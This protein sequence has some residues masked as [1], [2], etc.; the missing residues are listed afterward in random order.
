[1]KTLLKKSPLFLVFWL[2]LGLLWS[3]LYADVAPLLQTIWGTDDSW[4]NMCPQDN[5][6]SGNNVDAGTIAVSMAMIMKYFN[7]PSIGQ[8]SNSYVQQPYGVISAN[9]GNT[10]YNWAAM[11]NTLILNGTR[12]LIFHSGVAMN[13][14]YGAQASYATIENAYAALLNNFRYDN[15]GTLVQRSNYTQN[16]WENLIKNELNN[17]RPVLYKADTPDG[18]IGFV[19]DGWQNVN[20]F[21][22]NWGKTGDGNGY[23][24]LNNLAYEGVSMTSGNSAVIGIYPTLGPDTIDENFETDFSDW[25]WQFSGNANWNINT[26]EHFYGLQSAKSGQIGHNQTTSMFIQFFV[27]TNDVI[28]FY[29][30]VSCEDSPGPTPTY[31]YLSFWIDDQ[32]MARWHGESFW[33]METFPVSAGLRTFRWTYRKDGATIEGQDC[34]WID[35]IDFPN[36]EIPLGPVQNFAGEII[37]G[38][39]ISLSWSQPLPFQRNL[40]G[41]RIYKNGSELVS[42]LNPSTLNYVDPNLANGAY[43]YYVKA[44]YTTGLSNPSPT[45]NFNVEVPYAPTGLTATIY[46]EDNVALQ[47]NRPP[48]LRNRVLSGYNIYRNNALLANISDPDDTDYQD[49]DLSPAVYN[50]YVTALYTV[51]ESPASNIAVAAVGVPSPPTGL[52][53]T[54]NGGNNVSLV[55]Q[56]PLV[57]RALLGYKVFRN[58]DLVV[59][60]ND[61]ATLTYADL[62]LANGEYSYT[63][64]TVYTAAE[65]QPS[66]PA[67]VVI[68]VLYAPLNLLYAIENQINVRLSWTFPAAP[69]ALTGYN[70]YRN[71]VLVGSVYNPN[72]LFFLDEDLANGSYQ[73]H[74]KAVYT[75][76]TSPSSNTV[77]VNIEVLYPPRNVVA[78]VNQSTVNL[79]WQQP[80]NSGGLRALNGYNIYQ[81]GNQIGYVPVSANRTYSIANLANGSYVFAVSAVYGTGESTLT[82]A[83][84]A[85]VEVLYPPRNLS[86]TQIGLDVNLFWELPQTAPRALL[87]YTVYR[88]NVSHATVDGAASLSFSD[89]NLDTGTYQYKV[90]ARYTNG[91]S[92]FSNTVTINVENPYPPHTLVAN[93]NGSN[94]NLSWQ[95]PNSGRVFMHYNI[96]RG[97]TLLTTTANTSYVDAN[98]PNGGYSYYVSA[99][100]T[101]AESIPTNTVNATVLVLNPVRSF[102]SS[103]FNRNN[104]Q[105]SWLPP[106]PLPHGSTDQLLGYRLF[107]NGIVL[108]EQTETSYTDAALADGSYAY[109]VVAV[110]NSGTSSPSATQT[111]VIEYPFPVQNLNATV[112]SDAITLNWSLSSRAITRFAIYRNGSF[113]ANA[114]GS[115]NSYTDQGLAN[116]SYTY[117]IITHN[118]SESGAS[119]PSESVSATVEVLYPP[120]NLAY[121]QNENLISLTWDA[122]QTSG[123][124]AFLQYEVYR[125][126]VMIATTTQT[127]YSESQSNGSYTYY[128][129]AI[130]DSGTSLPSNSVLVNILIIYGP[131]N[132]SLTQV[133]NDITLNW[134]AAQDTGAGS[135]FIHYQIYRNGSMIG[136]SNNLSYADFDLPNGSYSYYVTAL[137]SIGESQAT[138]TV[139]TIVELIYPPLSLIANVNGNNVSLIWQTDPMRSF[140]GY[141]IYRNGS[142][143]AQTMQA[144]YT[145]T[146]LPNGSYQYSITA[147]YD[148][149]ESTHSNT[150]NVVIEILYA[151]A[152]LSYLVDG[153]S[154]TLTWQAEPNRSFQTYLVYRNGMP[155]STTTNT[156]YTDDSLAN[157]EY[158]YYVTAIYDTGE[159]LPS[160]SVTAIV[161]VLYAPANLSILVTAD[162]ADLAWQAAPTSSMGRSFLGYN[163]YRNGML[164]DSTMNLVYSDLG[165]ANGSYSYY[166]TAIYSSGESLPT[167]TVIATIEVLYPP[168][169][170]SASVN[171]NTVS[172]VWDLPL[173]IGGLRDLL[174]Y[175]IYRNNLLIDQSS[176]N[177]YTDS[178]LRNGAYSYQV[179]AVY[180]SG[181]STPSNSA[182]VYVEVLYAP[183][184][185]D[186]S[187]TENNVMLSWNAAP[188][189]DRAFIGYHIYRNDQMI[190]QT[191]A[192]SYADPAL[193]NGIYSYYVRA[194]Y[195]SGISEPSNTVLV[196]IE[197]LYP[198]LNLSYTVDADDVSLSWEAA[199]LRDR[200]FSGYKVFRNNVQIALT[201][202]LSYS[203]LN[204]ANG[205]YQYH[206]IASYGSGDSVPSNSVSAIVEVLYPPTGLFAMVD[207]DTVNLSWTAAAVSGGLGR[208]FVGYR[209]YRDGIAIAQV[210]TTTYADI[211]LANGSYT[212]QISA[213]YDSGESTLSNS[214]N[215]LVEVLYPATNLGFSIA[216][217]NVH[218]SWTAAANSGGL[219]RGFLGY[220]IYR[221]NSFLA[222]TT[223][224]QYTDPALTNGSYTY[225][226]IANYSSGD[227]APTPIVTAIVNVLYPPTGLSYNLNQDDVYLHWTAPS[228]DLTNQSLSGY[229]VY[230]NSML[231]AQTATTE[232]SD[233][234]LANGIYTYNIRAV[235]SDQDS[236]LS[237]SVMVTVEVPYS[238]SNLS[239]TV[240][241]DAVQ[242][243][244][245]MPP[246]SGNRSFNGYLIYR[247]GYLIHLIYDPATTSHLDINLANGTYS[248]HVV[249]VYSAGLSAPS[250]TVSAT[251]SVGENLLAPQNLMAEVFDIYNVNLSWTAPATP[252]MSYKLYRNSIEIAILNATTYTDLNLANGSYTYFVRAVYPEGISSNST[253]VV[254]NINIAHPPTSLSINTFVNNATLSWSAPAAGEI[255]FIVYRNNAEIAI[256]YDPQTVVYY[257]QNLPNGSYQYY[258]KALYT[259]YISNPSNTVSTTIE[260]T[261]PVRNFD[262]LV[263][264]NSA[265][266]FWDAPIDAGGLVA[267]KIYRNGVYYQSVLQTQFVD[268]NLTNGVYS[269]YVRAQY[270]SMESIPSASL[271]ITIGM[272]YTVQNLSAIQNGNQISLSWDQ[273]SDTG[274]LLYY[275]IGRNGTFLTYVNGLSYSDLNLANGSYIYSVSAHYSYGSGPALISDPFT[276]LQAHAPQNLIISVSA[277][278]VNL[279]WTAPLDLGGFTNYRIYRNGSVYATAS[280]PTFADPN[281][282]VGN[283]TYQVSAIYTG[284]ESALS[285]PVSATINS[286]NPPQNLTINTNAN[287]V[288]LSW[289]APVNPVNLINYRIYR[290]SV[291]LATSTTTS[292]QN[293]NLPNGNYSYYVSALY[294]HG[295]SIPT[296]SVET[297]IQVIYPVQNVTATVYQNS[298]SIVWEAPIDPIGVQNYKVYRNGTLIG[299]PTQLSYVDNNLPN[300]T[301]S[302]TVI[303]TYS[304]GDSNPSQAVSATIEIA[305]APQNVVASVTSP[306]AYCQ[307][308]WQSGERSRSVTGYQVYRLIAGN[309]SIP[310][311]WTLL[312][313]NQSTAEYL[314]QAFASLP[315]M[316]YR[317]AIKA[318]YSQGAISEVAFSNNVTPPSSTDDPNSILITK[319]KG[320]YPNPFN[321]TST[322]S[323][324]LAKP[325][326]VRIVVYNQKG[327]RVRVLVN[328]TLPAGNH[329]LIFDGKDQQSQ[330]LGSGVYLIQ[331]QA[332]DSSKTI[333]A[334]LKK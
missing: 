152:N 210:A 268:A 256:I 250:N 136:Q 7:H 11:S 88:N 198:P 217:N 201:S 46:Q 303:A 304:N 120:R 45:L 266:L 163:I 28:S 41:Y 119:D 155:L 282:A 129:K 52:T 162:R 30:R 177:S 280:T 328:E 216:Q 269:Y 218:L 16:A 305:Y 97:G 19:I 73:Y 278:N 80:I 130:Y 137:Y 132:L 205:V 212:Y 138:N 253:P 188:L 20:Q 142:I 290:N 66:L 213:L 84:V 227:S 281:L 62:N 300:G 106:N 146:N 315:V 211:S 124:R 286:I 18:P 29:K 143:I 183:V 31:D 232:Y 327:Q 54:V 48:V 9:F 32:E 197:I 308:N 185:L 329:E 172:L 109:F 111:R 8:G 121:S 267:Y 43:S 157:G 24:A 107:R 265:N 114:A 284:L 100:Y 117:Y 272:G 125:N 76:G 151:P 21:H 69:R 226:V 233:M 47:W 178:G 89:L 123:G 6:G 57:N 141:N 81:D 91:N 204:L 95:A 175:N 243:T 36:G 139:Q 127:S 275:R 74:V 209:I 168:R 171:G 301:Y 306:E 33:S 203:D 56:S 176:T 288:S 219:G 247:N 86:Y 70:I 326:P 261:H 202:E 179:S 316:P 307:V 214:I 133:S 150:V 77:T 37:N 55:W 225:Y 291:L 191:T 221:N 257:D 252:P 102:A 331:W 228:A 103:V 239:A 251:I 154:V 75:S 262:I 13:M 5:Q 71:N 254:V 63:V 25:N 295:E 113:L 4:N 160:G 298:V 92:A 319:L 68:E 195:D 313:A 149:G 93:V 134:Q 320:L 235:Y 283:Y 222:T 200:A 170:L 135:G 224:T 333:K 159:S 51:G 158:T 310:V 115:A 240:N 199:N 241:Q 311:S 169:N 287:N 334:I 317:Y 194:Q 181:E 173:T 128:I 189:R 165:L 230:R 10:Q 215:A 299:S 99:Q 147:L 292:Y 260:I 207:Q 237:N 244:W 64:S 58:G 238:P 153:D 296:N 279:A 3:S 67:A 156:S 23:F 248:Y 192:L 190:A 1:M 229:K 82:P 220:S 98:L 324:S 246:T 161:E 242:L 273:P 101:S 42:I 184:N 35:A 12:R 276:V 122:P 302:Y 182:D 96:Y 15:S 270:S 90:L 116:G 14:T 72:R 323:F 49:T 206:I 196:A 274:G 59:Q 314:D 27:P 108:S 166:V 44:I 60:I 186:F 144:N 325:E 187:L 293:T 85:N 39:D 145:D 34:A 289:T 40:S 277:N 17:G 297:L 164:H 193:A 263:T 332:G 174:H 264:G 322:L 180:S 245:D 94:V 271:A 22:V 2:L 118:S 234:N 105:I 285:N 294:Q 26:N 223:A 236:E 330:V 87:G 249:A 38:N 78:N 148:A 140:I 231:I 79:S 167:N 255:G 83:N 321:P 104:V 131:T 258:V 110:Y 112:N 312:N 208:A 65:S 50:Y 309:E 126:D 61:P 259:G 53:A 318:I